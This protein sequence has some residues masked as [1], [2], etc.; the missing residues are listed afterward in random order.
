ML[1]GTERGG[2]D[3]L[4]ETALQPLRENTGN[5]CRAQQPL[6]IPMD[7]APSERVISATSAEADSAERS[8]M[9][10]DREIAEF[11]SGE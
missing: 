2:I 6:T 10:A 4:L 8:T 11:F 5:I 1:H 7:T 9:V 3:F